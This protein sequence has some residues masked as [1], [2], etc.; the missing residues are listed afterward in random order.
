M[1]KKKLVIIAV[2]V[3]LGLAL[4]AGGVFALIRILDKDDSEYVEKT[5]SYEEAMEILDSGNKKEGIAALRTVKGSAA[6]KKRKELYTSIFGEEF[7]NN[8]LNA[9][10]GD[11]IEFGH[12]DQD[13]NYNNGKE[14][15]ETHTWCHGE[16]FVCQQSHTDGTQTG[17]DTGGQEYTVPQGGAH[18]EPG[19]QIRVQGDDVRHGHKGGET[20]HDFGSYRRAVPA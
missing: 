20:G 6:E 13:D 7:Y 2:S 3:I 11:V 4:I 12:F 14:A 15:V 16:G 8:I 1:N 18:I 19:Q 5:Y 9:K 17:G 10:V